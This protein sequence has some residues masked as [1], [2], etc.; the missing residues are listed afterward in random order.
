MIPAKPNEVSHYK[1]LNKSFAQ[2][3]GLEY[4]TSPKFSF[5]N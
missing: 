2:F 1:R 3:Y 5:K 4:L